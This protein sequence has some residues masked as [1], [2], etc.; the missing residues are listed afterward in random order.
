DPI[1]V[2]TVFMIMVTHVVAGL[3]RRF[4]NWLLRMSQ[5]IIHTTLAR[6][7]GTSPIPAREKNLLKEMPRD[8]RSARK[9]WDLDGITILYAACPSC[10]ML[11]KVVYEKGKPTLS[12]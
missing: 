10:H 7:C 9:K 5:Y 1:L 11:Q 2:L 6:A 4:C 8:I 12:P 3:E